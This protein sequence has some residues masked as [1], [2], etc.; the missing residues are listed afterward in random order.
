[1]A[2]PTAYVNGSL[3]TSTTTEVGITIKGTYDGSKPVTTAITLVSGS[4]QATVEPQ[5]TV[6]TPVITSAIQTWSTAGDKFLLTLDPNSDE[7]RIKGT[8]TFALNW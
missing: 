5:S 1:M 6:F 2:I 8:A 3:V 7:I 4:L